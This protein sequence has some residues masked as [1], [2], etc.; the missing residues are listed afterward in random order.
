MPEGEKHKIT[1]LY[2]AA[3]DEEKKKAEAQSKPFPLAYAQVADALERRGHKVKTIAVPRDVRSLVGIIDQDESDC[4]FNLCEAIARSPRH[5]HNVAGLLELFAKCFT[6]SGS[7]AWMLAGDKALCK[8]VFRFHGI[9]YPRFCAVDRGM[10]DWSDDLEFP[11]IV[12]PLNEDASLG[13]DAG[14][15]VHSIKELLERI[16]YIHHD[17]DGAAL[18]EEFIE[19]REIYVGVLGN[20][21]PEALPILEWDFSEVKEGP[22]IADSKAKWDPESEAF[23]A[24]EVF[25][26]DLPE[27]VVKSVQEAAVTAYQALRLTGYGRVDMRLRRRGH[28]DAAKAPR[29]PADGDPGPS[30]ARESEPGR[31]VATHDRP[32]R[33]RGHGA[34]R[35]EPEPAADGWECFVIEVNPN[36]WLEKRGE[37]AVAGRKH[38]LTYPQLL[39]RILDLALERHARSR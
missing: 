19:G 39:E 22:K 34:A 6:G 9:R 17:F 32:A 20:D 30:P 16:S 13:I 29:R 14:S 18:V 25:P 2:D 33:G 38:G 28:G 8:K 7:A 15:V 31:A 3:E 26:E 35:A 4:I 21:T 37:F 12:K 36:C 23:Q 27:E 24:P 11:L 1:V 5:E 10:T